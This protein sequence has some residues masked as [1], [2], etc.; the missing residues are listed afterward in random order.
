MRPELAVDV[1]EATDDR[2]LGTHE[3]RVIRAG[4]GGR[5]SVGVE[6]G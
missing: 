6:Q 5:D 3:G 2:T 1:G 4:E